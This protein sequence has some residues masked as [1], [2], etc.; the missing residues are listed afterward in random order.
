[1]KAWLLTAAGLMMLA[2]G[3]VQASGIWTTDY[4]QALRTARTRKRFV[5]LNFTGSD[6]CS[7]CRQLESQVF[8]RRDFQEYAR[9]NLVCVLLDSPQ[10]KPQSRT[11]VRQNEKLKETYGIR[12]F[13]TVIL[14]DP[15]G[16][17]V[18]RTGY[19]QGG[20]KPYVAYLQE[21]IDGHA[22]GALRTWTDVRNRTIQGT[23]V[24]LDTTHA[25]IRKEDG[26][27]IRVRREA[28]SWWDREFLG[29]HGHVA[30]ARSGGAD[31][32]AGGDTED[33]D[34]EVLRG[35]DRTL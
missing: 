14:L 9:G 2:V 5:L 15:E 18:G 24:G 10:R 35:I 13:P 32:P 16:N 33:S 4:E 19:R 8:A 34:D 28:L 30:P 22:Q 31:Q 29:K 20:P 27:R 17:E 7:W 12:A 21:M 25:T 6:W 1:M 23:L 3:S 26:S 11:V